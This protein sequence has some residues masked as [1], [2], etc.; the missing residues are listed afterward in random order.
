MIADVGCR[1]GYEKGVVGFRIR[2]G[3]D[4]GAVTS[5]GGGSGVDL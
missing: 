2:F 4:V 3:V 5:G 1:S